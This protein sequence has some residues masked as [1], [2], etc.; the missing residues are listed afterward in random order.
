MTL[1]DTPAPDRLLASYG[2]R[3]GRKLRS[4]PQSLMD[5]LLP[6]LALTLESDHIHGLWPDVGVHPLWLEIGFGG[7]EHLAAQAKLHP[8]A[9]IIGC[10]PYING[11]S[12]LLKYLTQCH[13]AEWR[14]P[15][16]AMRRHDNV[17][18]F[19]GDARDLLARLPEACLDKAFILFPDPWPKSKHHK[20]RLIQQPFL[21]ALAGVM[22]PGAVIQLATDHEDYL[23][24]MLEQLL[25]SPHFR[26]TAEKAADWLT[27]PEG[28]V[29][30]KYQSKARKE[31]RGATFLKFI[32]H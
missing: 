12:S 7:G 23:T 32:R 29:E 17:R 18:V 9:R 24:W 13:P 8:D 16:A 2:R 4:L 30:T 27:P 22:K 10:E 6:Q 3:R 26:W 5:E 1:P 19:Q 21:D 14:G 28:W 31:G 15:D 25:Q 11:I 20:R